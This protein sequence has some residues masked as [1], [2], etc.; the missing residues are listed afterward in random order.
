MSLPFRPRLP[1][2]AGAPSVARSVAIPMPWGPVPTPTV[3]SRITK[4]ARALTRTALKSP[5]FKAGP[6]MY[7]TLATIAFDLAYKYIAPAITAHM[8]GLRYAGFCSPLPPTGTYFGPSAVN[9]CAT[10]SAGKP[11]SQLPADVMSVAGATSPRYFIFQHAVYWNHALATTTWVTTKTGARP[12]YWPRM[13]TFTPYT[14][15]SQVMAPPYHVPYNVMTWPAWRSPYPGLGV[16][17]EGPHAGNTVKDRPMPW[18]RGWHWDITRPG[19]PPRPIDKPDVRTAVASMVREKKVGANS[20]AA[21]LVFRALQAKEFYSEVE[22]A[23]DALYEAFPRN[24]RKR[25]HKDDHA[26]KAYQLVNSW[27]QLDAERALWELV[28]MYVSDEIIGRTYFQLRSKMRNDIFG[29][30]VGSLGPHPEAF[31]EYAKAVTKQTEEYLE[32]I[33]AKPIHKLDK[34]KDV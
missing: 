2:V 20:T 33:W 16:L 8:A 21:Q 31:A 15:F 3:P 27:N 6:G 23:I 13:P 30:V 32:Q 14:Y 25:C 5:F 9:T 17:P 4:G 12:G 19:A 11:M 24:I 29:D 28:A 18:D 34:K 1:A 22:D 26:C 7:L 10:T